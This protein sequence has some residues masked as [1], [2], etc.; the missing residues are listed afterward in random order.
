MMYR[1]SP[2]PRARRAGLCGSV[3]AAA[4]AILLSAP[5]NEA[6]ASAFARG[7]GGFQMQVL[8]S[9]NNYILDQGGPFQEEIMTRSS[10]SGPGFT[11][12]QFLDGL[13][14]DGDL[15]YTFDLDALAVAPDNPVAPYNST[16]FGMIGR[17]IGFGIL[18]TGTEPLNVAVNFL[19]ELYNEVGVDFTGAPAGAPIA[20]QA[21]LSRS[22]VRFLTP[23]P[24][25]SRQEVFCRGDATDPVCNADKFVDLGASFGAILAP[26]EA[27][28]L[29]IRQEMYVGTV[30][31]PSSLLV[32]IAGLSLAYL[33]AHVARARSTAGP[34]TDAAT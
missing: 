7:V 26:G 19:F 34:I 25:E 9:S 20:F 28:D 32:L 27:F 31:E 13:C 29:L 1:A 4:L 10:T 16:A 8:T 17:T 5:S 23:S 33:I 15:C 6:S 24:S 3:L 21:A 2:C 14:Q 18:N 11:N 22:V 30:P 12:L